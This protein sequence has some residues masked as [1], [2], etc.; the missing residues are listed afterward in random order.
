MILNESIKQLSLKQKQAV[1]L[2]FWKEKTI[3]EIAVIMRISWA[4]ANQLI[5]ASLANLKK[6]CLNNSKFSLKLV[7]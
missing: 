4:E 1:S 2:R 7:V 5:D 6:L 3:E